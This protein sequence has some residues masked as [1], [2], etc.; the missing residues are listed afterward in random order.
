MRSTGVELARSLAG[1]ALSVRYQK[2]DSRTVREMKARIVDALGCAI[3]A[4]G[5]EPVAIARRVV[6]GLRG[7]GESTI[8]GS[9]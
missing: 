6:V 7:V 1:Y 9:G 2:L 8:F 5:E 3:G 4:Y